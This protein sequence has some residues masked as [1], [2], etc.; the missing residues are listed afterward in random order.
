MEFLR[1]LLDTA[2]QPVEKQAG[3]MQSNTQPIASNGKARIPT[4]TQRRAMDWSLVLASQGILVEIE[5][6]PIGWALLVSAEDHARAVESIAQ[7]RRENARWPW[8]Q[9]VTKDGAVFDWISGLWVLL[10]CAFFQWQTVNVAVRNTGVVDSAA[11]NHGEW[12][13]IFTAEFLH[14]DGL[15][16]AT[17]CVFGFILLGLAMGRFG[18]GVGFLAAYLGGAAGNSLSLL[19]HPEIH[20]ALGASGLVMAALGLL[21]APSLRST[22]RHPRGWK[23]VLGG[24]AAG[25][26][27]FSLLGL[28]PGTD[29]VAHAGGFVTGMGLGLGLSWLK[30]LPR[31]PAVN[32]LAGLIAAALIIVPWLLALRR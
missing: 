2:A 32:L 1:E 18:T 31:K 20:Q 15:H 3:K 9:S 24:I 11:I 5:S 12:W 14:A 10:T 21:A 6:G 28:H 8:Q 25:V 13:R 29:V 27:L 16:L 30:N 7:Y 23:L 17:N 4:R 26:M 19:L 22:Q